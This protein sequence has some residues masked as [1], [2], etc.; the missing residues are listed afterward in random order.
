MNSQLQWS[1]EIKKKEWKQTLIMKNAKQNKI[2]KIMKETEKVS[3]NI[4]NHQEQIILSE[5]KMSEHKIMLEIDW[6]QQHNLRIDWKHKRV[7]MKKCECKIRQTQTE[8]WTEMRKTVS[9][10][11]WKY[12]KLFMKS[13]ENQILSE[14]KS[15]D[16]EISLK[17]EIASEKLLIY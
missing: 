2:T 14:H 15:W 16:H 9:E 13:S 1:L 17:E 7:I 10:Q 11:Y 6:L 5:M 12:K 4:T 3:M 8:S